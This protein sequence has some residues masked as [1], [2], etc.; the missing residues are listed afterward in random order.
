V[1]KKKLVIGLVTL[2]ALAMFAL[3]TM[4]ASYVT[5]R[6]IVKN[7]PSWDDFGYNPQ[8]TIGLT[9]GY[10]GG[11]SRLSQSLVVVPNGT[12]RLQDNAEN[13]LFLNADGARIVS[14]P[15][16][17]L[18]QYCIPLA[19]VTTQ[20]GQI[21][22]I[23][24]W[25]TWVDGEFVSN[26]VTHD[27]VGTNLIRQYSGPISDYDPSVTPNLIMIDTGTEGMTPGTVYISLR[28]TG[29]TYHW[30]KLA[31]GNSN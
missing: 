20:N 9:Y 21:V 12:I 10:K 26:F 22:K 7:Q 14:N 8:T 29:I 25:R 6:I 16:S 18:L 1:F 2:A 17:E 11:Q 3:T 4:G 5:A 19:K 27:W 13:E 24:D 30:V 31:D 15:S 28:D 23:E